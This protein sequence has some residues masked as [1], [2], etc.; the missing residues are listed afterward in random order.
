M[1]APIITLPESPP[2][3]LSGEEASP[4]PMP[5]EGSA[6]AAPEPA[7]PSGDG[8]DEGAEGGQAQA[9]IDGAIDTARRIDAPDSEA[10]R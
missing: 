1:G 5:E 8:A 6:G 3:P 10:S 7:A 9:A 2:A 4:S